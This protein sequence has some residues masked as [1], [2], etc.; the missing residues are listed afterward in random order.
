MVFEQRGAAAASPCLS[1]LAV[2][3]DLQA[4]LLAHPADRRALEDFGRVELPGEDVDDA[5]MALVVDLDLRIADLE[6][7][8]ATLLAVEVQLA[9]LEDVLRTDERA[10]PLVDDT[11]RLF[12]AADP[13]VACLASGRYLSPA[14]IS[15]WDEAV[16]RVGPHLLGGGLRGRMRISHRWLSEFSVLQLAIDAVARRDAGA[17]VEGA[18]GAPS[19][20]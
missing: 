16:R 19:A 10:L 9:E 3:R 8:E 18:P 2:V 15:A 7:A 20:S 14:E 5:T 17:R 4:R 6:A 1:Y 11:E 13:I 12:D